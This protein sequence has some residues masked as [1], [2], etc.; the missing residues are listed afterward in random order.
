MTE[1]APVLGKQ[2]GQTISWH[3]PEVERSNACCVYCGVSLRGPDA[4]LSDKEHLIA[5]N[6]VPT[7][8][9]GGQPFNFI[10]RACR[11][12]NARK[13]DAER[14]V[15]SVTLFNSPARLVDDRVNDIALR[16][17][18][19]DY[20]PSKKGVL[21]QEA[22]EN[23]SLDYSLGPLSVKFGM[24][25]PPQLD[26]NKA[27]EVAFSH[28]QGLFT[29]ICTEDYRDPLKMRLLPQEQ[30]IWYDWY[31]FDDW[32]NPQALEI[33]NRVNDWEC[34]ANIVSAEGYFKATLRRS[35]EGWFWALEW[36]R[37]LRLVGGISSSSMK[38][39]EKLPD[40][41]WVLTPSGR[42]RQHVP[43]RIESDQL[44][45]GVVSR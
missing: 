41:G 28:V 39:F 25:A 32:G 27:G 21:I 22:H 3:A 38:V 35:D 7:G 1:R 43:H 40:E 16:K 45:A 23:L 19:G 15:S 34:L 33:A 8:T 36:N 12:C 24:V 44:F 5:R 42:M 26:K 17:G 20:H 37:Q 14:H 6:F 11:Q 29:L 4:P 13:A 31:A 9:M 10:F 2:T 30:F 18:R